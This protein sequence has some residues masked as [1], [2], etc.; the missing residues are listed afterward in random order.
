ML[1][2]LVIN[3]PINENACRA[4]LQTKHE[5]CVSLKNNSELSQLFEFCVGLSVSI[6]S[7]AL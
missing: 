4:C 7:Y 6:F 2:N 5:G 1:T 3:K